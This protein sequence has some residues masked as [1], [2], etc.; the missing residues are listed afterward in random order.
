MSSSSFAG[1]VS[2]TPVLRVASLW[3]TMD[4]AATSLPSLSHPGQA[5]ATADRGS[6]RQAPRRLPRDDQFFVGGNHPGLDAPVRRADEALGAAG[7]RIPLGIE[8]EPAPRHALADGG[9]HLG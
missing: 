7:T 3:S 6:G 2:V 8:R 4:M 1:S 9:A 5:V